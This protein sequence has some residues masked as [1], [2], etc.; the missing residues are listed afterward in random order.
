MNFGVAT[1]ALILVFISMWRMAA[2]SQVSICYI[3]RLFICVQ[4]MQITSFVLALAFP[5]VVANAMDSFGL[6]LTYF[7][8]LLLIVGLYVCPALIGLSIPITIYYKLQRNV[9]MFTSIFYIFYFILIFQNKISSPYHLQLA[10]HSQASIL[11][12]WPSSLQ[13]WVSVHHISS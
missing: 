7:S 2:V 4:V 6:S 9:S 1:T 13:Q 3:I 12:F 10:L 8:N 11:A 5:V